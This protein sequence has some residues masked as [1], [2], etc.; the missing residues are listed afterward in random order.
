MKKTC[1]QCYHCTRADKC[2][3]TG[4]RVNTTKQRDK[5]KHYRNNAP[6]EPR[7]YSGYGYGSF[8]DLLG[9]VTKLTMMASKRNNE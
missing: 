8:D 7:D 1:S 6:R 2:D 9:T 3:I 5:C 4:Q